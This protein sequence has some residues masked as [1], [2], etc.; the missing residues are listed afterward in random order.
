MFRSARIK[1]TSW[2]LLIIVAIMVIFSAVAYQLLTVEI[3]RGLHIQALRSGSNPQIPQVV[4]PDYLEHHER[5]EATHE[6]EEL[7]EHSND[8]PLLNIFKAPP[9]DYAYDTGLFDEERNRVF[10]ALLALNFFIVGRL[11]L[12][13]T[14]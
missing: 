7:E 3:R 10:L 6:S 4:Q 13:P 1:L 11:V 14:F 5:H 9:E 8:L 2:Y 12:P